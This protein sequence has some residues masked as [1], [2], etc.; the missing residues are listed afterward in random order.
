MKK[1]R[2][3]LRPLSIETQ[4]TRYA[5]GSVLITQGHT[6]VIC[7]A[8]LESGVP[9]FLKNTGKGWV[10]AEY[11]M[12]PRSTHDR[13]A[14][15]AQKGKQSGRTVEIARLIGRSLR[16][17]IDLE[18]LG[19]R[20]ITIDCDVIQADGG[21]RCASITGGYVALA[22]AIKKLLQDKIIT[23]NPLI[24]EVCAISA[25]IIKGSYVVDL[26]YELDSTADV[27]M[28]FVMLKSG[29]FVEIQGTAEHKPFSFKDMEQMKNL[30]QQASKK[31]FLAQ[32]QA[33][34]KIK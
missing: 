2:T 4:F 34:K 31:I 29:D 8:S 12:L 22:L 26:D 14:R 18:I 5:E 1:N 24:Q 3:T 11:G 25:G 15:E 20:Q 30:A 6:K 23:K 32:N 13:M 33:I 17:C 7:T 21:T 16:S 27:D 19:E 9:P 10:T 28:N